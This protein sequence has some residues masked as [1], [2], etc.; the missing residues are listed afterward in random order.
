MQQ[1]GEMMRGPASDLAL[2]LLSLSKDG[3]V[4]LSASSSSIEDTDAVPLLQELDAH[5]RNELGLALPSFSADAA[6]WA[7]RLFH[8][9]CRFVVCRDIVDGQ[10]R[11]ACAVECPEPRNPQTD[12]SADL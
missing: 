9:L 12:W 5:A 1:R 10:I 8:Q 6:L 3:R 7:A 4:T 2:C 11:A